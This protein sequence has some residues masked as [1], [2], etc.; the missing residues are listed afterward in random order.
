EIE[1]SLPEWAERLGQCRYNNCKHLQEPGCAIHAAL[2][3]GQID[4]QRY[5]IWTDVISEQDHSR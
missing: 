4:Q 1:H 2:E 3:Q 5:A